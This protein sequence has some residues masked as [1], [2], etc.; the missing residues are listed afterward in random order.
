MGLWAAAEFRC[1]W[2]GWLLLIPAGR[3]KRGSGAACTQLGEAA[4][5]SSSPLPSQAHARRGEGLH[6]GPVLAAGAWTSGIQVRSQETRG[7]AQF[8]VGTSLTGGQK[9][10]SGA[11]GLVS[12][13]EKWEPHP[14]HHT[15]TPRARWEHMR[16]SVTTGVT[17]G[18]G[19]S[20]H[21]RCPHQLFSLRPP[22]CLAPGPE[23]C[24][25][26]GGGSRGR[27]G[28]SSS[29][30]VAMVLMALW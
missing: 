19:N 4:G 27:S 13:H 29:S 10:H 5:L 17:A 16:A 21:A 28:S 8:A 12:L 11:L 6:H 7:L 1:I 20:S 18:R 26:G 14:G 30:E 22:S 24:G 23:P 3:E 15:P 2:L 25:G 9:G